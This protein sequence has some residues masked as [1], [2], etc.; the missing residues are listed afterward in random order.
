MHAE[1]ILWRVADLA[2]EKENSV[3]YKK[4]YKIKMKTWGNPCNTKSETHIK[5][6]HKSRKTKKMARQWSVKQN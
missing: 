1:G 6:L 4:P 3:Y 2:N 5:M